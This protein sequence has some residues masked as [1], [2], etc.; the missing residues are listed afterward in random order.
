MIKPGRYFLGWLKTREGE[1]IE[2]P[3]ALLFYVDIHTMQLRVTN[4]KRPRSGEL[5]Y[6]TIRPIEIKEIQYAISVYHGEKDSDAWAVETF[7]HPVDYGCK[8]I[9]SKGN[10]F[11]TAHPHPLVKWYRGKTE[12]FAGVPGKFQFTQFVC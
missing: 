2:F 9:S 8:L 5:F 4:P 1:K 3:D 6:R 12:A 10:L 7:R 11:L